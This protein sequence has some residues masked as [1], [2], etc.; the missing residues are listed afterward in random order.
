M[1]TATTEA[2]AS[3]LRDVPWDLYLALRELPRNSHL[4]M[5]YH[6]GTLILMSPE[7]VH[8]QSSRR[9]NKIVCEVADAF[10][11][12][13]AETGSTTF[14]R[15]GHEEREGDAKEP[16]EGFY[17]GASETLVRGKKAIDLEIDPPPDLAIEVDNKSDSTLALPT[18]AGL[19][20]PE[21]WRYDA[22]AQTLRFGRLVEGTYV[23]IDRSLCLPMLTPER[24]LFA[25]SK[26]EDIGG[27]TWKRWLREWA[28]TLPGAGG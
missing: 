12:E 17:I 1:A 14:R 25:L 20:V 19:L 15:K 16:D 4:R 11:V 8:D 24:V 21:L 23:T 2:P 3:V 18:Y 7:F 26:A 6:D 13:Y 9:L 27:M 22:R 5:T 28:G 10:D